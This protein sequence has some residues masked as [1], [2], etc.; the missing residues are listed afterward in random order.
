MADKF[1]DFEIWDGNGAIQPFVV[2]GD[3]ST[4]TAAWKAEE[5]KSS[6][7][8]TVTKTPVVGSYSA[9]ATTVTLTIAASDFNGKAGTYIHELVLTLSGVPYTVSTGKLYVHESLIT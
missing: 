9:G 5:L 2:D 3:W 8:T 6:S 7:P 4:A 1:Q